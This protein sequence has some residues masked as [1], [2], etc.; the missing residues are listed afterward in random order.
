MLKQESS[1]L[2]ELTTVPQG[3]L[4][5]IKPDAK[6]RIL[7]KKWAKYYPPGTGLILIYAGDFAML[8]KKNTFDNQSNISELILHSTRVDNSNRVLLSKD[9]LEGHSVV[10]E[11]S[12]YIIVREA[13]L[14]LY[15]SEENYRKKIEVQSIM[16][17]KQLEVSLALNEH[18]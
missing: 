7:I 13:Y 2:D 1:A 18:K 8:I 6:H 3:K 14:E 17:A 12:V 5:V 4:H 9:F 15:F 10:L 16:R 11:E